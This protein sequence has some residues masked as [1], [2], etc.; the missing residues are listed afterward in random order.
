M[1]NRLFVLTR[2]LNYLSYYL[3]LIFLKIKIQVKIR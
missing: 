2:L 3:L 1:Y